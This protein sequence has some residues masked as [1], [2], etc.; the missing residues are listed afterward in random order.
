MML[1][2]L[3]KGL[4]ITEILGNPNCDVRGVTQ[5][6]RKVQ[7]GFLFAA[8]P[9]QERDGHQFIA[10]ALKKGALALIVSEKKALI[11]SESVTQVLVDNSRRALAQVSARFYGNP[12]EK[13]T[14]IGITGT[15]GKTTLTFLLESILEEAGRRPAVLGTINYRFGGKT[16]PA[17]NTTPESVDL[18]S[19]LAEML[20]AGATD[21]VM[22]VSSHSLVMERVHEVQFDVAAFTNLSQDHLDF[23]GDL[24]KYFQAKLKLFTDFLPASRKKD[25]FAV[26]N[27]EEMRSE[28]IRAA[29]LP[30]SIKFARTG[31]TG[32]YEISARS[33]QLSPDGIVAQIVA[34]S[35]SFEI[36]SRLLGKFNLENILVAIG[37]ARCLGLDHDVISRG[38]EK[39]R[40]V[41]GRLEKIENQKG[42]L[43]FVD[44]AHTPQALAAVGANIRKFS[45]GR[46]ITVFG[47]GGDRDR[48]KRPLMG[49][50]AALFSDFILVTSDNP[51]NEDP[52]AIIEEILPG[53]DEVGF[54]RERVSQVVS[55]Q[56]ALEQ[57]V[58]LA[59]RG[60]LILVAGK[61]HEDYQI[62]KGQKVHFS[63]QEILKE[64]LTS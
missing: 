48:T 9:G 35:D 60:D 16:T 5:D 17:E 21:V 18:Q 64:L 8:L 19:L 45:R 2:E 22:E 59:R 50:E 33:F 55:R 37:I 42:F 61:G 51:R 12:S 27:M 40:L 31:L 26:L 29:V 36:R 38:I 32:P 24:E 49:R 34:G 15:N 47:C 6:S 28:S 4:N 43:V 54:P 44:Y 58:K 11:Q 30:K 20:A 53:I 57:A 3:I 63:D 52:E 25:K 46:I 23:H 10:Q 62:V 39:V 14:V 56:E 7:K 1:K 41:P 13:M